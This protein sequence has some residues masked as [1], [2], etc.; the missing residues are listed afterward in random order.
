MTTLTDYNYHSDPKCFRLGE[1]EEHS[2]FIPFE[3]ADK[4]GMEREKSA[5]F[6]SLCGEWAFCYKSSVFDMDDFYINGFDIS[7]FEKV[8]VPE[9]WQMHGKDM[10]QYTA[11]PYPF[12][13][14]LPNVPLKNPCA[15]YVKDFDVRINDG[16]RYELCFEGKDSCIYVWVNGQFVGYGEAPHNT[17][18]FDV[19]DKLKDGNNRL[20]VL[21]LKW[22]S[23]SYIDDQDKIRL[24]GLFRDVYILERDKSGIRDFKINADIK[25]DITLEVEAEAQVTAEIYCEGKLLYR[26]ETGKIHVD[27]PLLWT[28]ETPNLYTLKLCCGN[29]YIAHCFGFRE[30]N[31]DGGVFKVNGKHVKM[32]GVNRHDSDPDTG[33][34]VSVAKMRS[35]LILMKQHNINAVRTSHYPNDPRFY[36]LCDELGLYIMC[37]ADMEC[38]GCSYIAD[39][40]SIVDSEQYAPAIHDRMVRMYEKFKN[41]T[42]V[43]IWSLGNESDWGKNLANEYS[44]LKSVDT[45]RP[46]HYE[47]A[48]VGYEDMDDE[49]RKIALSRVDL[50]SRMYKTCDKVRAFYKDDY[51][52]LPYVKGEYS[53]AM[54][55]SC[56][57]LRFYDD[58]FQSDD[59]YMGGYIWEWC[60]HGL[61][62]QDEN[63]TEYFGYGGDFGDTHHYRNFCMDGLVTPDRVPHSS[64]L[65]AKAV[66]A[67]V[68][69]TRN[70]DKLTILNRN[71]FVD[72]SDYI[73][74]WSIS[75]DEKEIDSGIFDV[76]PS[77]CTSVNVKCP[78]K[79]P[80]L[81]QNAVLTVRVALANDTMWADK[82]HVIRVFSF[83]L[84]V[85]AE[86][87]KTTGKA[88]VLEE[89]RNAYVVYG[90]NF[91]YTFR[92][93]EG[94]FGSM[95][96]NGRELLSKTVEFNCFRAPLDNDIATATSPNRVADLWKTNRNF[97]NIEYTEVVINDFSARTEDDCVVLNGEFIFGV[98]GRRWIARGS[99]EYRIYGNG[100][101]SLHQSGSFNETMPYF[102]PRYGYAFSLAE[103]AEKIRYFGYGPA[104]CYED[105]CSHAVLG[106]YDYTPDDPYGAYERP[107][108][109]GSHMGTKWIKLTCGDVPIKV[110]GENLSFCISRYDVHK[111]VETKHRKDLVEEDGAFMYV[112]Y[113]MSGIGCASCSGQQPLEECRIN[114]GEKFDF[115]INIEI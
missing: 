50:A 114:A 56:G 94:I 100:K 2:Y 38:H 105:K 82:G 65:E 43:V 91:E 57:D 68:R 109:N 31:C 77:P 33:Y 70:G 58:I 66:F 5:Y 46:I 99:I 104:E 3:N 23:G 101:I 24:S 69:I 98:Q 60:E 88:P 72:F 106:W 79:E 80:Y 71:Y 111:V 92:K 47:A 84:E 11:A 102:L 20:C 113:R 18:V 73:I 112:D 74:D 81:A 9:I 75:A 28:A 17:S 36:E 6:H 7:G 62:M 93:D 63:G 96:V 95:K 1:M 45:Q 53:H 87:K 89:K 78:A 41:F 4:C 22:C 15:A 83:P 110:S 55:N 16:K 67:P 107:Q 34:A 61:R 44:Y 59:R 10:A 51:A 85:V 48:M 30:I 52:T 19:T 40:A 8:S 29:E 39:F 12:V 35:E 32:Y 97:G 13:I 27:N 42:S 76:N 21:V 14:N 108:E 64:L 115:T 26:G 25:G 90:D 86:E 103:P 49:Q 37:E 54:G